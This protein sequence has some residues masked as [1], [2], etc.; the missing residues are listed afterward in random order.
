MKTIFKLFRLKNRKYF[1]KQDDI[2]DLISN[3]KDCQLSTY[4]EGILRIIIKK[5]YVSEINH[6]RNILTDYL[7]FNLMK[8]NYS[9]L[10]KSYV[11]P[12]VFHL[13]KFRVQYENTNLLLFD[14]GVILGA[15]LSK[16][17]TSTDHKF[18][19]NEI[20]EDMLNNPVIRRIGIVDDKL[21]SN[22]LW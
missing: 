10:D 18:I 16:Q 17:L 11:Q 5:P 6:V 8:I 19:Q 3:F 4:T 2:L 20:T 7:P 13:E 9:P 14:C 22:N 12:E 1:Y 15:L 21:K